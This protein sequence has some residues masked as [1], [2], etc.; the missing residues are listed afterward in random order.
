VSCLSV[1]ER[2]F[3]SHGGLGD[4]RAWPSRPPH[5][6]RRLLLTRRWTWTIWEYIHL[7][8]EDKTRPARPRFV[9]QRRG[10]LVHR[11]SLE[12]IMGPLRRRNGAIAPANGW[13]APATV[14]SFPAVAAYQ[15]LAKP[16]ARPLPEDIRKGG[17]GG[18]MFHKASLIHDDIEATTPRATAKRRCTRA[19]RCV[20]LT[21]AICLSAKG[22]A[23]SACA[24]RRR[25]KKQKLLLIASQGQRQLCRG[26]GAEICWARTPR[27]LTQTQVLD[28]FRKKT[29][30]AFEVAL[31]LGA[32]LRR[33][34]QQK[35]RDALANYA[36]ALA[37]RTRFARLERLGSYKGETNDIAGLRPSLLLAVAYEK[38][39]KRTRR[40][41][42]NRSGVAR[43][44]PA[45][46][47]A[48]RGSLHRVEG[49]RAA[50]QLV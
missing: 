45:S 24:R 46:L 26:Q 29:L 1:L 48:N 12:K 37:S 19:W 31:R 14:A 28:I 38:S 50:R 8:S 41:S 39:Q 47:R 13:R 9:A 35:S 17:V 40:R 49:R 11:E 6:C 23:S 2:A 36:K 16:R 15:A 20:A 10:L 27:P 34:E 7:T 25:S 30:R 33:N 44:R 4:S 21:W 42:L 18:G 43:P 3:P 5:C 32:P 22:I